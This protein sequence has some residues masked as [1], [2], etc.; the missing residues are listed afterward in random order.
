MINKIKGTTINNTASQSRENQH[1]TS[2]TSTRL[3]RSRDQ[4]YSLTEDR[5]NF[6]RIWIEGITYKSNSQS[7][8]FCRI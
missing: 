1:S 4:N 2:T 3:E 7:Q 8:N 6:I 5:P